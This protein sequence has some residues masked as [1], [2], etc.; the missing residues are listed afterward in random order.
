[1]MMSSK[2]GGTNRGGPLPQTMLN[3]TQDYEV[4]IHYESK[5]RSGFFD[6]ANDDG[7]LINDVQWETFISIMLKN[8][9]LSIED[10]K[11]LNKFRPCFPVSFQTL[12]STITQAFGDDSIKQL[13]SYMIDSKEQLENCRTYINMMNIKNLSASELYQLASILYECK[14]RAEEAEKGLS[15]V[16]N[17]VK[18]MSEDSFAFVWDLIPQEHHS[19]DAIQLPHITY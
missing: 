11:K 8:R 5:L 6:C 16:V 17:K 14:K 15:Q 9:L 7:L 13:N 1:M 4:E 2:D 19:L 12:V 18:G 10:S 3:K